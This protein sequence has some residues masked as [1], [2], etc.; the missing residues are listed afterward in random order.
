[1]KLGLA[2]QALEKLYHAARILKR[3][4]ELALLFYGDLSARS[5]FEI[6]HEPTKLRQR[7][8]TFLFL[9]RRAPLPLRAR[10]TL[11]PRRCPHRLR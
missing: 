8:P 9:A 5:S 7:G 6:V 4:F 1:M 3:R 2:A 10:R 11:S